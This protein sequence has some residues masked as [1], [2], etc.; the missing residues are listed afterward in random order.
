MKKYTY[1][2]LLFVFYLNSLA[3]NTSNVS[4]SF[5]IGPIGN[6]TYNI[7]IDLPSG[8]AGLKPE[9][10]IVYNSFSGDGIMGKGFSLSALSSISRVNSTAFHGGISTIHFDNTDKYALDGNRLMYNSLTGQYRTEMNPYSQIKIYSANTSSAHFEVKTKEGL[11]LEYGNTSDSRLCAQSPNNNQVAFWMLNKVRDRVGNYY[12]YTYEKNESTGEIRLKQIDYTGTTSSSPYCTIKFAYT[13]RPYDINLNYIAGSKFKESKM[14]SQIGVYYGASLYRQYSMTYDYDGNDYSYLLSKITVTGLNNEVL[15]PLTFSWYK[16]SDFKQSQV[17]YDQSTNATN[18]VNK[19]DVSLGD[20][21]GDGRTDFIATPKSNAGWTG[22]RLF[23]A[24]PDGNKFTYYGTGALPSDFKDITPGDF[25]GDGITDFMARRET[26]RQTLESDTSAVLD[27]DSE[28][29]SITYHN[30]FVFYGTGTG[31]TAG[32][33]ITTESRPHGVK[34]ADFNGDAAMDFFV[35]YTSKSGSSP[36]YKVCMSSYSSGTLTAFNSIKEGR[37]VADANW[38]RVEVWDF[39]GDGLAEIIS[40]NDNGY[41]YF[42]NN[43]AGSMWRSKTS[44]FPNKNHKISF[45]DFNGD[46]KIDL[47]ING[48]NN[49]EWSEW[50]TLLSTG[51]EFERFYFP[52]KFD[53]YSKEIFVYDLNGDGSDDFFAVDK[54]SD[55]L[56]PIKCFLGYNNGRDFKEYTSVS[57]YGLDKWDFYPL[58]TRGDGKMGFMVIS[59]THSWNG[60]QLYMP[61]ADFSNLLKS[62]TDSHGSTT[63]VTYTKMPD[64]SVYTKTPPTGGSATVSG[65][66]CMS[67]TAPFKLVSDVSISNGIG[68]VNNISYNY[69]NA[70]VC[71]RG[72]GFLGFTKTIMNDS[73]TSI[74]T[75]ITQEFSATYYQAATK[76]VEK[77][78]TTTNRKLMQTDYVNTLI[79]FPDD[80]GTFS[81]QPTSVTEQTY[82][83]TANKLVQSS[84]TTCSYDTYGNILTQTATYGNGDIKKA[85]NT[86]NNNPTDWLLGLLTRSVSTNTVN[87]NSQTNT[88]DYTYYANGLLQTQTVEPNQASYK[89]VSNY[90]YD[91][92]GNVTAKTKTTGGISRSES[93]TYDN[94]RFLKTHT[95]V[96]NQVESSVYDAITSFL[97][98]KTD[99]NGDVSRYEYDGFGKIKS[100]SQSSSSGNTITTNWTWANG[101]PTHSVVLR[102][103]TTGDGQVIKTW[104]DALGRE[105]QASHKNFLGNEVYTTSSYD[106]QGRAI[107]VSEPYY[108][109]SSSSSILYHTSQYDSYGRISKQTMPLGTISYSYSG[110]QTTVDDATKGHTTIRETDA[111]GKLKSVT[112]PGGQIFYTYGPSG[113]PIKVVSNSLTH[114]MEYDLLGRRTKLTDPNAGTIRYEYDGWGNLKKQTDGR[115]EV[116]EY[117]YDNSGRVQTYKRG[118]ELFTYTYDSNYK[119]QIKSITYGATRT[120]FGYGTYGRLLSRTEM[121]DNKS[122]PFSYVYNNKGQLETTTYPNSKSVK[123]E[124][125]NGDLHKIIWQPT[126][127]TVWQKSNENAKG[128]ILSANLGNSIQESYAYNAIGMPTS[129]QATKGS[130]S[131]LNISYSSIDS[132]GNILMRKDLHNLQ[133]EVF[134]YDNMN[135]LT[136]GMSYSPNGNITSKAN[137]GSYEYDPNHPHA[138]K[139][140]TFNASA[141]LN[142]TDLSVIYNSVRMPVQLMEGNKTYTITYNGENARV[143]SQYLQNYST[144]FTKYYCGPYEEIQKGAT[145]QKNYYIY[146]GGQIAAVYTEG[147]SDAGM[148]YFHN[149]HLSSPWLITNA[150]GA[151]VQRLNYDAWGRRRD[152]SNW[153]N[154]A[155]LPEPKFDRGFTGH[156]HLD[157]FDLVNMNARLYDPVLGRFLSP[158]PIIQVPEFTQSYNGYTYALNNPLSYTDPSGESF[159]LVAAILG[160]WIGMGNAMISSDKSGWGLVGDMAKGLFVGAAG[161]AAGA[162]AGGAIAGSITAGGFIEGSLSGIA[163]GFSGGF[164][165][166]S[167]DAWLS[168]AGFGAGLKAGLIGGGISA[169]IGGLI[170]GLQGVYSKNKQMKTFRKGCTQLNIGDNEAITPS[171]ALL[172]KAREVWYEGAPMDKIKQFTVEKVPNV[173]YDEMVAAG[174][175]ARTVPLKGTVSGKYTG[176]SKIYFNKDIA[177]ISAKNLY[178]TMGHELVHVSQ[179]AAL[180]G[181]L[182]MKFN[183]EL[184]TDLLE[185]H[186]YSYESILGGKSLNSFDSNIIKSIY[187]QYPVQWKS[188]GWSNFEWTKTANFKYPF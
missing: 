164:I 142:S 86:Y 18:Y 97:V 68:G 90:T 168:G 8:T 51:G 52:K 105:I 146:A 159:I 85:T 80:Y 30:Y 158:D 73:G 56:N 134:A 170:G 58:D 98:S 188:M 62:M 42:E 9:I 28:K 92:Y 157:M 128:Q 126:N 118:T 176:M 123:Y 16:N 99:V 71:K 177:F 113:N 22:W 35:Y 87:G 133:T 44:N 59:A 120:E 15:K 57:T 27:D 48:W 40:F 26:V 79:S 84:T 96:L 61:S 181:E 72:R 178:Y 107:K 81:F 11:I 116:E 165:G 130:S 180:A 122:F 149:D 53:P 10:S 184:F 66:D 89:S 119:S 31:F 54:S 55:K 111:A 25:N 185:F 152:A 103:E 179:Y 138:V 93:Y 102:T 155:N 6:A 49:T 171:D 125:T 110:S 101:S 5:D 19:A 139:N 32:P 166:S 69:E 83:P 115:G 114:T 117:T 95:N 74:K 183:T 3:Q 154:Y 172:N 136:T 147:T 2:L 137:V 186:A 162:W 124:Y 7:P 143:K 108:S 70:K 100:Q 29:A 182:E 121:V 187:T 174:A 109:G 129:I 132:R 38:D 46:R 24:D 141:G 64:A 23:L 82:E 77:V 75:A 156:E 21:N 65:Y 36:D 20:F 13:T 34:V 127:T 144:V 175:G 39:N 50:L 131:L 163:G 78:H 135:R 37:I 47:L 106:T 4:G 150:S 91:A 1:I 67:F 169:G 104:Y 45:G 160:G 167:G 173:A 63:T 161:G 153:S 112:D 148:Y 76:S 43:G 94:G 151:E 41:D 140:V 88:V 60:Y 12:T 14:L 33:C 145:T 17:V